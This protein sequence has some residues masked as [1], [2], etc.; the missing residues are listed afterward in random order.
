MLARVRQH[1]SL[2]ATP[3]S[4]GTSR[5]I[6]VRKQPM[7]WQGLAVLLQELCVLVLSGC[8]DLDFTRQSLETKGS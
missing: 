4:I 2:E 5:P 6:H 7:P 3:D 8:W 1:S